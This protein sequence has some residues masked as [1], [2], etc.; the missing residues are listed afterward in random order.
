LNAYFGLRNEEYFAIRE[1]IKAFFQKYQVRND[2]DDNIKVEREKD[3]D[4]LYKQIVEEKAVIG[5]QLSQ[6]EKNK[7]WNF[8]LLDAS[9]NRSY[10]NAIYP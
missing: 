3:F 10:G 8:T 7:L 6:E 1:N 4:S 5:K 2:N 9:T